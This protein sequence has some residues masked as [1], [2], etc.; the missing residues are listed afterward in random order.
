MKKL[1]LLTIF[2]I[3]IATMNSQFEKGTKV[4]DLGVGFSGYGIPV[5]GNFEAF[6]SNTVSVGLGV[7]WASYNQL[8]KY[9]YN[10]FYGGPRINYHFNDLLKLD[11]KFD[12][13]GGGT[14]GYWMATY[15]GPTG[16]SS[17][18]GNSLFLS[19]QLGARYM[20][21]EK[22]GGFLEFGGGSISGGTLGVTFKL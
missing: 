3:S 10:F 4:A 21:K 12:I 7:N 14:L 11:S 20:F 5:H 8:S 18:L 17:S 16:S 19:G 13:Y 6:L 2:T 1:T 22:I 9:S 15:S